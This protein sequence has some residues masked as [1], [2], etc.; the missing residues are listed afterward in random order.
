[1][2]GYDNCKVSDVTST[3]EGYGFHI[4]NDRNRSLVTLEFATRDEA[5]RARDEIAE[6]IAKAVMITPHG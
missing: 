3:T 6:V 5:K 2:A 4:L 1:M